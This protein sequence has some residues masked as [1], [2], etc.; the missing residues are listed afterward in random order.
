MHI[1]YRALLTACAWAACSVGL[2]AELA[3]DLGQ[4]VQRLSTQQLLARPD[5][6]EIEIP[7]DVAYKTLMRYRAVPMAALLAGMPGDALL[8]AIALDGFTADMPAAPLLNTDDTKAMAWL[9]IE[10]SAQP[11]PDIAA[12]KPGAGPFY[13][14]WTRP[15]AS[16]IVPEQWPY[17]IASIRWVAPALERF[18]AMAPAAGLAQSDPI[19]RG[20]AIF[21]TNCM[22]CHT[23]NGQGD[24][25]MGPDLNQPYSPTQYL[26]PEFL[27]LYIRDPQAMR[28]WPQA[29][30]PAFSEQVISADDLDA[31]IAYLEHMAG[32]KQPDQ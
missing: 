7:E 8:Q 23:M 21:R 28:H 16:G 14:V 26:K 2:A 27:R 1:V 4:G 18:P 12:G 20:F 9:A 22:V 19:L 29:K 10:D 3:V 11:W 15:Q 13:L 32:R 31:L 5:V 24:A 17:Q 25:A 30:M 6:R